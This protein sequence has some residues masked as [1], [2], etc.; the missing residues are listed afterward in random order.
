MRR[1]RRSGRVGVAGFPKIG[2]PYPTSRS[3]PPVRQQPPSASAT[4]HH[5]YTAGT[6]EQKGKTIRDFRL[7][8]FF[9]LLGVIVVAVSILGVTVALTAH[10]GPVTVPQKIGEPSYIDPT[11]GGADWDRLIGSTAGTVG[12]AVANVAS[13]PGEGPEPT[14]TSVIQREHATGTK[15][16]G[17]VDTG[18]FGTTGLRTRL[19]S[20]S[21]ADWTSQIEQDVSAW[22]AFYGPGIDGIFF[23]EGQGACGPTSGSNAWVDLYGRINAYVKADHPG[24]M[25]AINAGR[26]VPRCYENT[27]DVLVTFEGSYDTYVNHYIPLSWS[28]ADPSKIWHLIYDASTEADM[29]KAISLSKSR[30]AG[31]VYVTNDVQPNPYGTLPSLSYWADEEARVASG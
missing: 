5:R 4:G 25:T 6:V 21:E 20:T 22:F 16:L 30:K 27:E 9:V 31:N 18:Y 1:W 24:A 7:S 19:G 2:N 10:H 28:P 13:G 26:A 15:V 11:T 8:T 29:E 23:D 12:I 17:Y 14:W 3:T